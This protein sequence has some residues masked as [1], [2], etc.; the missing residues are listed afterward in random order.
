MFKKSGERS[1]TTGFFGKHRLAIAT[2][3]LMGTIIGAGVLGIPYVVAKSGFLL[4]LLWTIGLGL[5]FLLLN[6]FVGEVVLRTKAVHQLAGYAEK[7]LG[8]WGKL[9]MSFA[10][11]FGTYGALIAYLI[12]EGATLY[13]LFGWGS[14]LLFSLLFFSVGF[15]IVYMGMKA[16]GKAELILVSLLFLIVILLGAFSVNQINIEHY[17]L[18]DWSFAFL[19]YGVILFA[20]MGFAAI[21]EMS[22]EFGKDKKQMKKA[23][24]IGSIIPIVIYV[25]FATV[26]VGLVGVENFNL[27]QPN[28]RI[29]TIALSLYSHPVMGVLANILAI[30]TMF[31]SFLALSMALM[32]I[33]E[34][35]YRFKHRWAML[36]TFILPLIV[37]SLNLT[38]FITLLG[39]VGAFTGGTNAIVCVLMYWKAKQKGDRKPEYSLPKYTFLGILLIIIFLLG[40]VYEVYHL[41]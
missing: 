30:L 23:I 21:P 27:L 31:T 32:Q 26:V 14:P 41:L 20:Y 16:T 33:Y 17:T 1:H 19:P 25:L 29:A 34:F 7:Y 24:L 2:C 3:T 39:V 6:L 11:I 28:E 10:V 13:T 37:V 18:T 38:S 22:E 36:L 4:G 40:I 9:A 35:D 8:K 15:L 12:G 5:A